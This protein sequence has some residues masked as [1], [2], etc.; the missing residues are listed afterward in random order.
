MNQSMVREARGVLD[1]I[2]LEPET[3][4]RNLEFLLSVLRLLCPDLK[5]ARLSFVRERTWK[6]SKQ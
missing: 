5:I 3:R 4:P 1:I 6:D 2:F